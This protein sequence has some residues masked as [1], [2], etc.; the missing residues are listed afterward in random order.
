MALLPSS[1]S[2][3]SSSLPLDPLN[4]VYSS[5]NP[6]KQS[7][8]DLLSAT[9]SYFSTHMNTLSASVSSSISDSSSCDHSL[10]TESIVENN[11]I[12]GTLLR[13]SLNEAVRDGTP[14]DFS[15]ESGITHYTLTRLE[16]R[17]RYLYNLVTTD[18]ETMAKVRELMLPQLTMPHSTSSTVEIASIGGGPGFD[19]VAMVFIQSFLTHVNAQVNA[20]VNGGIVREPAEDTHPESSLALTP[21]I[22][23]TTIYDLFSDDWL[24]LVA[25]ITNSL[26]LPHTNPEN[27]ATSRM[28]DL[29]SDTTAG[30]NNSV[31]VTNVDLF[32]F[33]FVLHENHSFLKNDDDVL[34]TTGLLHEVLK[35]AKLGA[36]IICMDAGNIMW[37]S[38]S[39][40]GSKL[41]WTY[42]I[43][44]G[45]ESWR[46][47]MG[48][49]SFLAM[50]R[51]SLV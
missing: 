23:N 38:L 47:K 29:R 11:S 5:I 39:A 16:T 7:I 12:S 40:A 21:K 35:T 28:C 49:K 33:S 18:D 4:L 37:P 1:S 6:S 30:V 25:T 48:P 36:I 17:C 31:A 3:L 9:R 51:T 20:Q 14:A 43:G 2:S 46:V 13:M 42:K 26:D 22:I 10:T 27:T 50:E 45:H 19:H 34:V 15:S 44:G 24:P 32:L 8:H 41:G